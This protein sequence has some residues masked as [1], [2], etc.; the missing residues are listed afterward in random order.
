MNAI[1]PAEIA[2]LYSPNFALTRKGPKPIVRTC[3]AARHLSSG[4]PNDGRPDRRTPNVV[5]SRPPQSNKT[6]ECPK[7]A[8]FEAPTC[9]PLMIRR[10]AGI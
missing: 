7:V 9:I 5:E 4:P 6:T 8:P 1:A 2:I 10:R 3:R